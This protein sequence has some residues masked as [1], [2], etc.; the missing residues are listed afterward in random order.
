MQNIR[1]QIID[2][3]DKAI[4]KSGRAVVAVLP[5]EGKTGFS[6]SV[7]FEES[8]GHPEIVMIGLPEELAHQ[9]INDIYDGI[10]NRSVA[11]PPQG[12]PV[13]KV[14]QKF[15]VLAR[16]VPEEYARNIA[17]GAFDRSYPKPVRLLQICIPDQNGNLPDNPKC[18]KTYVDLQDYKQFTD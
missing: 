17:R 7:G 18:D 6:Y 3:R 1:Q 14:V 16:P 5:G 4:E 8:L 12:G 11:I 15:D 13:E 10:R 2:K 9:L